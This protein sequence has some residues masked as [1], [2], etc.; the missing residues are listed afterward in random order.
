MDICIYLPGPTDAPAF[1]P[2]LHPSF[3]VHMLN[4]RD[5]KECYDY[6]TRVF[7]CCA[8]VSQP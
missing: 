6:F 2:S 7:A 5:R 3:F 4:I 1:R 8:I